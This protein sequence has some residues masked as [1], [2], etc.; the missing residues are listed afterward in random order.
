MEMGGNFYEQR[1]MEHLDKQFN[2]RFTADVGASSKDV[3]EMICD[4]LDGNI[5]WS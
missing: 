5:D 2:N 4:I 3:K 1:V